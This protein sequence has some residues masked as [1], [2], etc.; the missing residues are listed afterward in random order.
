M[1][2]PVSNKMSLVVGTDSPDLDGGGKGDCETVFEG[3][4]CRKVTDLMRARSLR[5]GSCRQSLSGGRACLYNSALVTSQ[6]QLTYKVGP[7]SK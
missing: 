6:P 2:Q 1:S 3:R 5:E 7:S 4:G